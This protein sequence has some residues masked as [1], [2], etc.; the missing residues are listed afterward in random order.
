MQI[1]VIDFL[2]LSL[3][4]VSHLDLLNFSDEDIG[5]DDFTITQ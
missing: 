2:N 3:E 4:Q 5:D 1:T